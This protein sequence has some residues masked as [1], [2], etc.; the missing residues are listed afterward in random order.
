M[1]QTDVVLLDDLEAEPTRVLSLV[2]HVD[3]RWSSM[4]G[5]CVRFN[6]LKSSIKLYMQ[7]AL[8]GNDKDIKIKVED[9][10]FS[11]GDWLDLEETIGVLKPI[12]ES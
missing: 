5:M 10:S 12:K 8:S 7:R 6:K 1:V 3:V 11:G 9:L 4:Y 2:K